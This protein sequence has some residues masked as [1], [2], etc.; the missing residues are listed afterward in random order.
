[1]GGFLNIIHFQS[2]VM[3]LEKFN[4]VINTVIVNIRK[5]T[6]N[7]IVHMNNIFIC[8]HLISLNYIYD[9]RDDFN[10]P[11]VN[12]PFLDSNIAKGPTYGAYISLLICFARA[13]SYAEDFIIRHNC[14]IDK[15][16]LQG[17]QKKN[18]RRKFSHFF[19]KYSD[20]LCHLKI[21]LPK[22]LKDNIPLYPNG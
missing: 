20:L 7:D 16:L 22:F 11:I 18:L 2:C 1:M 4:L 17:F 6:H 21:D 10:F 3:W 15:L 14:L 9:K 19:N 12:Y 8:M 13:C 5:F